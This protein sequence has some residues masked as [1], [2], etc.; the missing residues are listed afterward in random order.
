M[1]KWH[2][3]GFEVESLAATREHYTGSVALRLPIQ[4]EYTLT[5]DEA[6]DLA[7]ALN[8]SADEADKP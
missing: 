7:V 6:R 8:K 3:V 4:R 1:T 5:P 2:V